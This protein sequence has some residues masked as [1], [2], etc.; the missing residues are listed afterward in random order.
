MTCLGVLERGDRDKN[1][2]NRF[3]RGRSHRNVNLQCLSI[4]VIALALSSLLITYLVFLKK[5]RHDCYVLVYRF[6]FFVYVHGWWIL[7]FLSHESDVGHALLLLQT[8]CLALRDLDLEPGTI[9]R[10]R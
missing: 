3:E 5:I 4:Y 8:I 6:Q 10:F 7:V 9:D 2:G 1:N